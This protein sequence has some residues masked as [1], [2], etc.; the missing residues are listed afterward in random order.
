MV[1]WTRAGTHLQNTIVLRPNTID[2]LKKST[3][4]KWFGLP[5]LLNTMVLGY[6]WFSIWPPQ[7]REARFGK[8][9]GPWYT[10]QINRLYNNYGGRKYARGPDYWLE[11]RDEDV[12]LQ[13]RQA[14]KT[15]GRGFV[16]IGLPDLHWRT[17]IPRTHI[18]VDYHPAKCAV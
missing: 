3:D 12:P 7:W 8:I 9:R 1:A 18:T 11:T 17:P 2:F 14:D 5:V 10:E 6:E 15:I 13:T 16:E 4:P